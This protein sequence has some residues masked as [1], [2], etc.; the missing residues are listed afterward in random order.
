MTPHYILDENGC[1]EVNE[2]CLNYNFSYIENIWGNV[3]C[4]EKNCPFNK[5]NKKKY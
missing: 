4:K 3:M 5:N 2:K 1:L